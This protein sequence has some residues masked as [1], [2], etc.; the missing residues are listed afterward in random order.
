M[1]PAL[2]FSTSFLVALTGAMM[3][4]PVLAVTIRHSARRGFR[5]GPLIILGHGVLE[6]ALIAVLLAGLASLFTHP[7]FLKATGAVGGAVL[8]WMG[9]SG[10]FQA[11]K[12]SGPSSASRLGGDLM[13]VGAGIAASVSNPYW[14]IW[15]STVGMA[16]LALAWQQRWLGLAGFFSGHILA[17]L[18]WYSLVALAASR[19]GRFLSPR[20][21]FFL[22]R[23]CSVFMLLLGLY[24]LR[25]A[26][27]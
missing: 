24:F 13:T 17:D 25:G 22:L 16:Y 4:G 14:I 1:S 15:W 20:F 6:L 12:N 7:T 10:W 18:A 19:G 9:V 2:L 26:A 27:L 23:G 8:I 11:G 5:S 21:Q 3:P